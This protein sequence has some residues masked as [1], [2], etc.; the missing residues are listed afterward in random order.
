MEYDSKK[1]KKNFP[2]RWDQF[3][4]LHLA[5]RIMDIG[6]ESDIISLDPVAYYSGRRL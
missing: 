5:P 4:A 2:G 1:K 6:T 3:L